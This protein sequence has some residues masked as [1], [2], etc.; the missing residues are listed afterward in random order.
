MPGSILEAEA[1][2]LHVDLGQFKTKL[3]VDGGT[4]REEDG[5]DEYSLGIGANENP[6]PLKIGQVAF[7][8]LFLEGIQ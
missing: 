5:I 1:V 2:A 8:R 7:N 6:L 3:W 4:F